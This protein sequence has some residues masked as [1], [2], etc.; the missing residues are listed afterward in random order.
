MMSLFCIYRCYVIQEKKSNTEDHFYFE[1][2]TNLN[3]EQFIVHK[4][5]ISPNKYKT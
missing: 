2:D 5:D 1:S 3:N 4:I